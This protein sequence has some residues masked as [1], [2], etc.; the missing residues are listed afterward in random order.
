MKAPVAAKRR[1][2]NRNR[3]RNRKRST[4]IS[5]CVLLGDG[6][7][8]ATLLDGWVYAAAAAEE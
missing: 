4:R 6:S 1:N 2:R 3:N 5:R 7:S 8:L